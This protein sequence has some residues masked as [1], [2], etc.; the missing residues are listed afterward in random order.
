MIIL[1]DPMDILG[2]GSVIDIRQKPRKKRLLEWFTVNEGERNFTGYGIKSYVDMN[3]KR[4]DA[5]SEC[6]AIRK[7]GSHAKL[8][9]NK[10]R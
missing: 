10:R 1:I 4:N 8:I 7:N 3:V 2:A 9:N 6:L 5:G